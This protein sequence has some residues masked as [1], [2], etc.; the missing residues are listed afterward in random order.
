MFMK[1]ILLIVLLLSVLQT[2]AQTIP[3]AGFETWISNTEST[4]SYL[5]P[6]FWISKDVSACSTNPSYTAAALTRTTDSYTGQYAALFQTAVVGNDTVN[7]ALYSCDSLANIAG[8]T[9]YVYVPSKGFPISTKPSFLKMYLKLLG[10]GNDGAELNVC[11]TKWN[12]VLN[13]RDTVGYN[14]GLLTS[15]S[16]SSYWQFSMPLQYTLAVFPDTVSIAI[17]IAPHSLSGV[18]HIGTK[19]YLDDLMFSNTPP[20]GINQIS[21]NTQLNIYPNPA[22][23]LITID[24]NDV[25]EVK[26][27]DVVGKQITS[28]QQN[29]ID[30][31]NFNNG[32]YFIQ[33]QTK[34]GN[35]SQKVIVQH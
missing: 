28:T 3:N 18:T 21:E 20:S 5:V 2:K 15:Y 8:N 17:S 26:L 34:Q 24:A 9:N 14:H 33:V 19:L 7:G 29:Q 16:F 6:Q 32:V 4:Q 27:F 10:V 13:K 23:N 31:S 11:F 25:V 12:T 30:V 22:N 1:K 35:T